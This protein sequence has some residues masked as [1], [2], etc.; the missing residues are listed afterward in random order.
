MDFFGGV[1]GLNNNFVCSSDEKERLGDGGNWI[2]GLGELVGLLSGSAAC[3]KKY[4]PILLNATLNS[5]RCPSSR[6]RNRECVLVE[7]T[8][9]KVSGG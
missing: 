9:E 5:W 6:D 3:L 2:G 7:A 4:D 1:G 8:S